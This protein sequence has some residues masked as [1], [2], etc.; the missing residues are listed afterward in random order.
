M[1]TVIVPVPAHPRAGGENTRSGVRPTSSRGSSPRG[2]GKRLGAR[3]R[4]VALRLIPAR[5]GKTLAIRQARTSITAHPRAGGENAPSRAYG[6]PLGGSSPRGRGKPCTFCDWRLIC[7]LIPARAGKTRG[8]RGNSSSDRA[9]PRAGG[10]NTARAPTVSLTAGSSPR[11]RGKLAIRSGDLPDQRLIPAR[12]GKTEASGPVPG[13][14]SAHPRAGGENI[15]RTTSRASPKGSSP[16]GRGKP[17]CTCSALGMIG[18]IPARAGKTARMVWSSQASSAH[19]RAGGENV[20]AFGDATRI[21]GSSPRGRGKLLA[22][23]QSDML[24]RLIPARA[25]KTSHPQARSYLLAAHPRAGGENLRDAL[26]AFAFTGSSPRGRG[27]RQGPQCSLLFSRLIPARAGKTWKQT[28]RRQNDSAHPRAG[29][30]N[31]GLP[32]VPGMLYGSSPRGRGKRPMPRRLA[33][34]LGLI[35]ARAGKTGTD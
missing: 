21:L 15:Q 18:L 29:G 9:H 31:G 1:L 35:P 24:Q 30:E 7:W 12:A 6:G 16:R 10:E 28:R 8:H 5:A 14:E 32:G 34:M 11:G 26:E 23:A 33:T 25:G 2:R 17:E 19:P 27:K 3:R 22:R 20:G 4:G 13:P